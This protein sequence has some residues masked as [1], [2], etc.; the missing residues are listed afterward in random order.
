M[1]FT[2]QYKDIMQITRECEKEINSETRLGVSPGLTMTYLSSK[3]APGS[4]GPVSIECITSSKERDRRA[5][6]RFFG[7]R[8]DEMCLSKLYF[9]VING[10]NQFN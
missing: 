4:K 8:R 9:S 3:L 6:T 2:L 10:H 7:W 1:V 5:Q